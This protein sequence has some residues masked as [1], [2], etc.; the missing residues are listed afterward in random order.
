[1]IM[2]S[3]ALQYFLVLAVTVGGAQIARAQEEE[4]SKKHHE[5]RYKMTISTTPPE[6]LRCKAQLQVSYIQKDTVAEVDTTLNN[7]DCAA[8]GGGYT[9]LVRFRDKNNELQSM[10]YP[11]TWRRDDDQSIELR[12]EYFIGEDVDLVSV[13][14]RKLQCICD[15]AGEPVETPEE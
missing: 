8:S 2:A 13:R 5:I 3:R 6:K 4:G 12:K 7:T 9:I 11:E 15:A 14:S 10:E 1:M